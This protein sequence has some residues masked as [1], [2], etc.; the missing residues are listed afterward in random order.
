[1]AVV[2]LAV[3]TK[4]Q[5]INASHEKLVFVIL[6]PRDFAAFVYEYKPSVLE[7]KRYQ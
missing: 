3:T 4:V 7:G 6:Y 5:I 1:M 2:V